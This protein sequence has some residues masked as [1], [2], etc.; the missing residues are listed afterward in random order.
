MT[1][2]PTLPKSLSGSISGCVSGPSS[3]PI[4]TESTRSSAT[5]AS[6][7]TARGSISTP[8]LPDLKDSRHS[9]SMSHYES[10]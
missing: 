7:E 8:D 3:I 5:T 9:I 1:S 6:Y 2:S 4:P 10:F